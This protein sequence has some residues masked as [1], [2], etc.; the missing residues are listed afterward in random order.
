MKK[1]KGI[2]TRDKDYFNI[3]LFGAVMKRTAHVIQPIIHVI[4]TFN[5]NKKGGE[6][7]LIFIAQLTHTPELCFGRPEHKEMALSL[8]HI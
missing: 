4:Q 7:I 8:I 3:L 2:S 1:G 6:Y 5:L